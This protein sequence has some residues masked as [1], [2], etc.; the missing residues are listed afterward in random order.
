MSVIAAEPK[1]LFRQRRFRA[2]LVLWTVVLWGTRLINIAEDQDL[3]GFGLVSAVGVA[4]FLIVAAVVVGFS[5]MR[6]LTWHGR[7]LGVLVLAGVARFTIRGVAIL[8]NPE[9]STGFKVVH[10][11]L[12]AVTLILSVLAAREYSKDTI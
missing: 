12:W 7:A 10:T 3:S 1:L 5:M 2:G 8:A 6:D 11:A 9:W 4:V